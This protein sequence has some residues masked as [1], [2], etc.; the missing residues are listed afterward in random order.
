M[1]TAAFLVLVRFVHRCVASGTGI[2]NVDEGRIAFIVLRVDRATVRLFC[3][4]A[5][6]CGDLHVCSFAAPNARPGNILLFWPQRDVFYV[7]CVYNSP[8]D[9]QEFG[10]GPFLHQKLRQI[11]R[12]CVEVRQMEDL[13]NQRSA[14]NYSLLDGKSSHTRR[15]EG[16]GCHGSLRD[17]CSGSGWVCGSA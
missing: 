16:W 2:T 3:L 15:A 10:H 12:L 8:K 1:S 7:V 11:Q 6:P 13:P 9:I 5:Y 14:L 4:S 17:F